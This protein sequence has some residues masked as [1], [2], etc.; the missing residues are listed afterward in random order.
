M[1][2]ETC[3]D[4]RAYFDRDYLL[5]QGPQ[6]TTAQFEAFERDWP[7]HSRPVEPDTLQ[8]WQTGPVPEHLEAARLSL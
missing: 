1:S 7:H 2:L 6:F 8:D 4:C 3:P 5:A